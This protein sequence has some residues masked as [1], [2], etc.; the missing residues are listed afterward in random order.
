MAGVLLRDNRISFF[1]YPDSRRVMLS[2]DDQ[3]EAREFARKR[4]QRDS[5]SDTGQTDP[6]RLEHQYL[7]GALVELAAHRLLPRCPKPNFQYLE[8]NRKN[9][10]ADFEYLGERLGAKGQWED[11]ARKY[12]MSWTYQAGG[13]SGRRDHI[14]DDPY[15]VQVYGIASNMTPGLVVLKAVVWSHEVIPSLL[16]DPALE[17]HRGNKKM[18]YYA[19]LE[20]AIRSK[21]VTD[22]TDKI[23]SIK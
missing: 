8:K 23:L 11:D 5:Y 22:L 1:E 21:H 12:G 9:F 18:I 7:V 14:L 6:V 20:Q 17:K 15:G 4:A 3:G 2:E 19:A 10:D 13:A 16:D